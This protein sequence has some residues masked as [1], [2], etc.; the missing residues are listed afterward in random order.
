M[1]KLYLMRHGHADNA[2]PDIDRQL[3]PDGRKLVKDI[4]G[5]LAEK[6]TRIDQVFYSS[7]ERAKQ[8]A[9][10]MC[11]GLGI[12]L[13]KQHEDCRIYNASVTQLHTVLSEIDVETDSVLLVGHN[14]GFAEL[15][16]SLSEQ[17]VRLSPGNIALLQAGSWQDVYECNCKL[18]DTY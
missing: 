11:D 5:L 16:V 15:V 10:L 12:P 4:V 6:D 14:P 7:A 18:V 17:P 3:T 2:I 1:P 8:T 13:T 9:L